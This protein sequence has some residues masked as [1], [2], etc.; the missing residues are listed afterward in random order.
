MNVTDDGRILN[1]LG[2]PASDLD[3]DT[4]PSLTPG[5]AVRSVQEA[6]RIYRALPRDSGPAGATRAT[7][8]ADGTDAEL[9]LFNARLAWRVMYHASSSE[10]YD[11]FVD[12]AT[13]RVL[14][15][16]NMVKSAAGDALVWDR[17]PGNE[18]GGT[19]ATKNFFTLGDLTAGTTTLSG[20]NVLTFSDLDDDNNQDAGE[21]ISAVAGS[22]EFPFSPFAHPSCDAGHL[23]GW[24]ATTATRT[25]NREQNGVQAF[26]LANRFYKDTWKSPR[27][28]SPR[29]P[30]PP[31]VASRSSTG[32]G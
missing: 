17:F 18:P 4:T 25:A 30:A 9:T 21:G 8:Y 14:Q 15:R 12:A 32:T 13:G 26:Y 16:H 29:P 3:P 27:S 19:A 1:V 28:T 2:S 31:L 20:P 7:E 5:E 24:A 11:A 23:C 10:V 22:F 6:V